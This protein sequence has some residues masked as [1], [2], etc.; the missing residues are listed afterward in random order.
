M[1]NLK[2]T[3]NLK[4]TMMGLAIAIAALLALP[5]A[6]NQAHAAAPPENRDFFGTVDSVDVDIIRVSLA[7]ESIVDVTVTP[8][9]TIRLPLK[10]DAKLTDLFIGDTVAVSMTDDLSTASKIFVIPGKWL[11][12]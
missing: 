12:T 3:K 6:T 4:L 1:S 2:M 5:M 9:T 11:E 10:E 7:D 8:E